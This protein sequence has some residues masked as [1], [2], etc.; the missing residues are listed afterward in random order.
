MAKS[1]GID[2]AYLMIIVTVLAAY[3]SDSYVKYLDKSKNAPITLY[4]NGQEVK[5][6][7]GRIDILTVGGDI[8]S[9]VDG[10]QVVI[11]GP[12]SAHD[13]APQKK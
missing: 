1:R 10:N 5:P 4:V 7:N 6:R 9:A 13:A 8:V 11:F 3:A 12:A 2:W